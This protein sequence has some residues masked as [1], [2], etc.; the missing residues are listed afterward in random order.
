MRATLAIAFTFVWFGAYVQAQD[1]R[2]FTAT[3][4]QSQPD[5]PEQSGFIAKAGQNM[6]FEYSQNGTPVIKILRPSEGIVLLL[7]PRAETYIEFS[8]PAQTTEAKSPCPIPLPEG[9]RCERMGDDVTVSGVQTERWLMGDP[10]QPP[11]IILWDTGRRHALSREYSDGSALRMTFKAMETIS[12]REVEHW[13][14]HQT[15]PNQ[16]AQSG[17][18]WYDPGLRVV[19]REDLPTGGTRRLEDITVGPVDPSLFTVPQ[20]WQKQ[21]APLSE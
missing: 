11:Q 9:I 15:R 19:I 8:G 16:L 6:R 14:I 5:Q 17:G 20:G 10:T 12:G 7:D 3:A 2:D 18:W 21:Q 1:S 13:S 4:I